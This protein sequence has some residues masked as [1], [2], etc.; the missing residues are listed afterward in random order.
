M[1]ELLFVVVFTNEQ[2]VLFLF[3]GRYL[4]QLIKFFC[5]VF[6]LSII[7]NVAF[8]AIVKKKLLPG[9]LKESSCTM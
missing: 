9:V 7:I 2:L 6:F 8:N 5:V 4:F 3:A 1:R